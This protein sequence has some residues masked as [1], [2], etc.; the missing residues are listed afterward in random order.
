[1]PECVA[2]KK[3]PNLEYINFIPC[4]CGVADQSPL[5]EIIEEM[6]HY[7]RDDD[8]VEDYEGDMVE[9][10]AGAVNVADNK[11]G[12]TMSCIGEANAQ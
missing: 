2:L 10:I 7:L 11:N 12:A 4:P 5:R 8:V 9:H 1:M 3:V 6:K